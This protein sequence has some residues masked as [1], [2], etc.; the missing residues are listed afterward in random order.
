MNA[1]RRLVLLAL[2]LG[3]P[4]G[5]VLAGDELRVDDA[6]GGAGER[7]YANFRIGGTTSTRRAEMCLEVSPHRL[8][9]AEACGSGATWFH[10]DA[11]PQVMHLR[12]FLRLASERGSLGSIE[13]RLGLGV[14]ELQ[15]GE[16]RGGLYFTGTG[17]DGVETAGPELTA[18][19]RLLVP[20]AGGFELLGHLDAAAAWLPHAPKLRTPESAALLSL[21]LTIG[22]GF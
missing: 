1:L 4:G 19:A 14:A 18:S 20:V 22:F 2:L 8:V 7:N 13:P 16:D 11:S 17:P 5:P 10:H 3:I 6:W 15:V 21:A 9:S 12:A